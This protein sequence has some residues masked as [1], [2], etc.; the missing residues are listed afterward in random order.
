MRGR[1]R[2]RDWLKEERLREEEGLERLRV[3]KGLVDK[4]GDLQHSCPVACPSS[5]L[6]TRHTAGSEGTRLLCGREGGNACVC[7]Y[8]W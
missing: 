1:E 2:R 6:Q 7:V 8:G 5:L 4:E 3:E